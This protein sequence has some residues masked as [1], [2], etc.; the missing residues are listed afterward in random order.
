MALKGTEE[1][2]ANSLQK[3]FQ[4]KLG[5][6]GI[7][8]REG[9]DPPDIYLTIIDKEIPVE[10]TNIDENTINRRTNIDN[11]FFSFI[12]NLDTQFKLNIPKGIMIDITF[13]HNSKTVNK[14]DKPFRKV[15]KS[16]ING[17]YICIE[18]TIE[19]S[20][21]GIGYKIETIET[22]KDSDGIIC[23][24]VMPF[25][26]SILKDRNILEVLNRTGLS[27]NT[28]NIVQ[29]RIINKSKKCSHIKTPIYLALYDNHYHTYTSFKDNKHIEHYSESL[30]GIKIDFFEKVFIIFSNGDVIEL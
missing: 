28:F 30:L 4:S 22:K 19:N 6:K 2:V 17:N 13:Y 11:G 7:D 5:I 1:F 20:I 25:S 27:L 12:D 26:G 29:E 10:I 14:I 15:I 16:F 21:D 24:A 3:Y 23:G 9:E 18:N 8:Y